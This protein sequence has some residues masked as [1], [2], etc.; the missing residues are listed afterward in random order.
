MGL[1]PPMD[2]T[3]GNREVSGF[4]VTVDNVLCFG[5][6]QY[7]LASDSGFENLPKGSSADVQHA[8]FIL[9]TMVKR[10]GGTWSQS[11]QRRR[12]WSARHAVRVYKSLWVCESSCLPWEFETD[13][14]WDAA[15]N[16]LSRRLSKLGE[17]SKDMPA[18]T[19]TAVSTN[20]GE[21][22]PSLWLQVAS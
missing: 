21:S 3:H 13:R 10:T 7:N 17:T 2:C 18:E 8:V 16:L 22:R 11:N 4:V 19:A 20:G 15:L 1:V 5:L 14:V 9:H 6:C 12:Q